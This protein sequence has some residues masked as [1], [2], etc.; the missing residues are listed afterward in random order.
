MAKG[1][2]FSIRLSA[3]TDRFVDAEARRTRRSK[4]A[5]VETLTEEA[6]RMRRF[7]GIGFRGADADRRAWVI[8][9][10]LDVWQIAEAIAEAGSPEFLVASSELDERAVRLAAAY[11][12]HYPEEIAEAIAEN[13]RS[14]DELRDLYPFI[15]VERAR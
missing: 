10:G 2:P 5:V 3:S 15:S 13:R 9:S 12:E 4:S 11:R 1:D 8:G 7:P 6:A 14:L